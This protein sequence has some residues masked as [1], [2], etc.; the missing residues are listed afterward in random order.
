MESNLIKIISVYGILGFI[1]TL[2]TSLLFSYVVKNDDQDKNTM[3]I[4]NGIIMFV[5]SA[6]CIFLALFRNNGKS[7]RS[8]LFTLLI[9]GIIFGSGFCSLKNSWF[10]MAA[11]IDKV[12]M[13]TGGSFTIMGILELI[14]P[15][16]TKL[17][18]SD[19]LDKASI[20]SPKE[21]FLYVWSGSITSLC[22]ALF[23]SIPSTSEAYTNFKKAISLSIPSWF[24]GA[25][26]SALIGYAINRRAS[27][28]GASAIYDSTNKI[29]LQSQN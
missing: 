5:G 2:I 20:E 11:Y 23:I 14:W 21:Q 17:L 13:I 27:V 7:S 26:L 25:S 19:V 18:F 22:L 29:E 4:I 24:I 12:V 15:L 3:G 1:T 10:I 16:V 9:S 8:V 6:I 28:I